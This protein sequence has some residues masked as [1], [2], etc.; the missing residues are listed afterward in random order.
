MDYASET[1]IGRVRQVNQDRANVV[2]N[3]HHQLLAVVCDGMGG[4][5]AGEEASSMAIK[6]LVVAFKKKDGFDDIWEARKWLLECIAEANSNVYADSQAIAEHHGMGTT[7]VCALV[8]EDQMCIC[9]VGD[10]RAYL[11]EKGELNQLT[12]DHTYVNLLVESGS[13]NREQAL[14]HPQKNVLM[15]ALGVFEKIVVSHQ[16]VPFKSGVLLLCSDGLYNCLNEDLIKQILNA[17]PDASTVC[18][19][20]I[21]EANARGGYDN[22]GVALIVKGGEDNA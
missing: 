9:H 15:K 20:L 16:I 5:Q 4:H 21:H 1:N 13:I 7:L 18:H 6:E 11:Y 3:A 19:H 12:Q 10:S 8:I 17:H 22:I 2:E 14:H